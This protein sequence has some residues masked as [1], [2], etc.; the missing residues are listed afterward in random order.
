LLKCNRT[1]KQRLIFQENL[2][3]EHLSQMTVIEKTL[4]F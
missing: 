4:Q 1:L 2:V 3:I